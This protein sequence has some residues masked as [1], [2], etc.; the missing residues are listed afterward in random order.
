MTAAPFSL[1]LRSTGPLDS[2][3]PTAVVVEDNEV[4][5]G[6]A[7]GIVR[8]SAK[9]KPSIWAKTTNFLSFD[10]SVLFIW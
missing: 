1:M 3:T 5:D 2:L 4:D 7:D 10:A 9:S 6:S 8:K